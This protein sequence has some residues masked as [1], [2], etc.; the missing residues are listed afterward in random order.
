MKSIRKTIKQ[1]LCM[2]LAVFSLI[3]V[4]TAPQPV[5]ANSQ[6]K[7]ESTRVTDV[8]ASKKLIR[9]DKIDKSH[10]VYGHEASISWKSVSGAK[11]YEVRYRDGKWKQITKTVYKTSF[12]FPGYSCYGFGATGSMP[13]YYNVQVRA[14]CVVNKRTVYSKWSSIKIVWC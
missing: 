4:F 9:G 6:S 10:Y 1:T 5:E 14:F 3:S 13:T 7:F 8:K 12:K 11:G 2:L